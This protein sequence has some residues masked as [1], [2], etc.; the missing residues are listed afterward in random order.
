MAR[1]ENDGNVNTRRGQVCLKIEAA[2]P[3]QPDVED[4]AT[5][6]VRQAALQEFAA[7]PNTLTLKPTD[8]KRLWRASR[9][10]SSSSTT[11]TTGLGA[12]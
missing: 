11:R 10:D 12:C 3:G 8:R 9:I 4:K 7:E 1:H 5:G 2:Q 6:R